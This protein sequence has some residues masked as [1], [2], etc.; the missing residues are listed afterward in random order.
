MA[1][2]APLAI[3]VVACEASA[4]KVRP[5]EAGAVSRTAAGARLG[6]SLS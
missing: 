1:A 5:S 4:S 3:A 2:W 6:H